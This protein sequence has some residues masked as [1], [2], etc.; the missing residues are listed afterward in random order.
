MTLLEAIG[1]SAAAYHSLDVRFLLVAMQEGFRS[2]CLAG[3]PDK[4]RAV[5]Q[6]SIAKASRILTDY[7]LL[8]A[9]CVAALGYDPTA[10]QVCSGGWARWAAAVVAG[11]GRYGQ[12]P[13]AA[14]LSVSL[15]G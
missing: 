11:R 5:L 7:E 9:Q 3:L 10:P 8:K 4:P 13:G 12:V 14:F 2:P 1:S 6:E 15:L